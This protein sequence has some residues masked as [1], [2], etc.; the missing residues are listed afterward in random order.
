MRDAKLHYVN[1]LDVAQEFLR[2]AGERRP[3]MAFDTETTGLRWYKDDVR[4]IQVGD[5]ETGWAFPWH[6]WGGLALNCISRYDGELVGHNVPFDVMFIES[7]SHTKMPWHHMNDSMVETHLVDSREYKGLKPACVRL[8]GS[9]ADNV[10][11]QLDQAMIKNKWTWATVPIDFDWYWGYA[12][13]DTVLTARLHEALRPLITSMELRRVYELEMECS[14]V[15]IKM[16]RR[17]ARIDLDYCRKTWTDLAEREQQLRLQVEAEYGIKNIGSNPQVVAKLLEMEVPLIKKT[18]GGAFSL[19]GE[20]LDG[21]VGAG[22]Q[23]ADLVQQARGITKIRSTYF[24]NF[25]E[26]HVDG[27]LHAGINQLGAKTGR[28][29][30]ELLQTNPRGTVVRDAFI[31]RPGHKLLSVDSD[32]IEM[33][34][35]AHFCQ[36][37]GL[38]DAINSGDLHTT[39]AR[40]VYGDPTLSKKDPR[41]QTAKNAGFAKIYG[42][43]VEKFAIT[44]GVSVD[45][46]RAFLAGYDQMFPGVSTWSR[47]VEEVARQRL[48][49]TG[50]AYVRAP[51]GR[52]HFA[53]ESYKL[54]TLVNY[55]IQGTA[56]DVLKQQLVQLDRMGLADWAILPIHDEVIFDIPEDA[57]EDAIP[58]IVNAMTI[59]DFTVPIT[60][61]PEGPLD[62]WGDKYR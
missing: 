57:V 7:H 19:D 26:M 54:Y 18:K 14:E 3:V 31:P 46:A 32:Q 39:T 47:K 29:S 16:Q 34:L 43:G 23:L 2:W 37:P 60:V 28:M 5:A 12:A 35:L 41:R 15:L 10:Q 58:D 27:Y 36:D 48:H 52:L 62:R 53:E 40:R 1:N 45:E 42:A 61:G 17:G 4:L 33:R 59:H 49:D 55:L 50:D 56:A 24:E 6:E 30:M 13:I 25:G 11:S 44:A 38:I 9:Y 21:L 8:L 51:S 20:V 22:I